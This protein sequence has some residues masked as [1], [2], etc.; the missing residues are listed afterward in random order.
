MCLFP[1]DCPFKRG[2]IQAAW[3]GTEAHQRADPERKRSTA[4][5]NRRLHSQKY[6]TLQVPRTKNT[7]FCK[8]KQSGSVQFCSA[9][10]N[11]VKFFYHPE[12]LSW[13]NLLWFSIKVDGLQ[14]C[15]KICTEQMF[16][17]PF[18]APPPGSAESVPSQ[19][20]LSGSLDC[21]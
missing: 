12:G 19:K 11:P 5:A 13:M 15:R 2:R 6:V 7:Q 8:V 9:L 18:S 20:A 14:D 21:S 10:I 1:P 3:G 16:W 17:K 4:A